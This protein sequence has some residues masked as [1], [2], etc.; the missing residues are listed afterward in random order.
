MD[1]NYILE[2]QNKLLNNIWP[3]KNIKDFKITY[4]DYYNC[5]DIYLIYT[6]ELLL[7]NKD[8]LLYYDNIDEFKEKFIR[9]QLYNIIKNNGDQFTLDFFLDNYYNKVK[10][11]T[12]NYVPRIPDSGNIIEYLMKYDLYMILSYGL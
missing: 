2:D 1:F 11:Y 4:V 3:S 7:T 8:I 5:D 10:K 9:C 6:E 12:S